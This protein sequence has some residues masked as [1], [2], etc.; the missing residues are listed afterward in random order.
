MRLQRQFQSVYLWLLLH[1]SSLQTVSRT[2]RSFYNKMHWGHLRCNWLETRGNAIRRSLLIGRQTRP[3]VLLINELQFFTKRHNEMERQQSRWQSAQK[4]KYVFNAERSDCTGRLRCLI[5]F[6]LST[7]RK[8]RW[9]S[10]SY[11]CH[12]S[13][14]LYAYIWLNG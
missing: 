1:P 2:K 4:W 6:A 7:V 3:S 11:Y 14:S 13:P 5:R 10:Y 9:Q 12:F 8:W